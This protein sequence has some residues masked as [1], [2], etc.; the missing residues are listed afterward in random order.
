MNAELIDIYDRMTREEHPHT[1]YYNGDHWSV[2][3]L[4]NSP[5]AHAAG[6]GEMLFKTL[7]EAIAAALKL[8]PLK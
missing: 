5:D 6:V 8:K 1:P 4:I 3:Y 7:R 2:P